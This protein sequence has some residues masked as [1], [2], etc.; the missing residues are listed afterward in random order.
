[1][2]GHRTGLLL[3]AM[4]GIPAVANVILNLILIPRFGVLGAAWS[5]AA[6]FAIG[7]GR[8]HHSGARVVAMP[9]P[10]D[11]DRPLRHRLRR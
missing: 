9:V 1:M 11:D 10:W 3:L 2:L 4:V 5:T 6:S 8:L 7:A